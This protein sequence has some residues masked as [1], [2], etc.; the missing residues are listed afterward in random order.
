[1]PLKKCHTKA[2]RDNARLFA[3]LAYRG[4]KKLEGDCARLLAEATE[5]EAKKYG[6]TISAFWKLHKLYH[7]RRM[8]LEHLLYRDGALSTPFDEAPLKMPKKRV[9]PKVLTITPC[10]TSRI[11]ERDEDYEG[12]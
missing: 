1:M 12:E 3:R 7:K 9:Y 2:E 11:L 10:C 6:K 5:E 4:K 8:E